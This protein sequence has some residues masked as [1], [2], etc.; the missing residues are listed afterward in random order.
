MKGGFSS[1]ALG[2]NDVFTLGQDGTLSARSG[3]SGR[4]IWSKQL[5]GIAVASSPI[6]AETTL[7]V[8]L[9]TG[10]PAV[11]GAVLALDAMDGHT[12]WQVD[13]DSKVLSSPVI[14][15]GMLYVGDWQEGALLAL[16]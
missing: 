16:S 2:S 3:S 6:L 14:A 1:P 13:L 9:A 8:C 12:E 11:S 7:Y 10:D 5:G 4:L 15:N